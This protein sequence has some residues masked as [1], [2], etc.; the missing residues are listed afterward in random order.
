M[1]KNIRLQTQG[2]TEFITFKP[3]L[4]PLLH[5]SA[6]AQG[7]WVINS[8][9]P[10]VL[11]FNY[12]LSTNVPNDNRFAAFLASIKNLVQVVLSVQEGALTDVSSD[13]LPQG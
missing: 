5:L 9:D 4:A 3:L 11:K 1:V 2:S 13:Q 6:T 8:V 12:Y 7:F 10:C